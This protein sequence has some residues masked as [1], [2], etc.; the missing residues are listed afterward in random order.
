MIIVLF[1]KNLFGLD[2]RIL[3]GLLIFSN[4][5]KVYQVLANIII[6][7]YLIIVTYF[8]DDQYI[9]EN[10]TT[11][12]WMIFLLL[13]APFISLKDIIL[14]MQR[15]G[16]QIFLI[17]ILSVLYEISQGAILFLRSSERPVGIAGTLNY[18]SYFFAFLSV[19]LWDTKRRLW[20]CLSLISAFSFLSYGVILGVGLYIL[21]RCIKPMQILKIIFEYIVIILLFLSPL[22]PILFEGVGLRHVLAN[23]FIRR[24]I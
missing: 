19:I 8:N 5:A 12:I 23:N 22:I 17:S 21:Y 11:V 2:V 13:I 4:S 24:F 16:I 3:S 1:F 7:I 10:S 15:Y 14:C 20:A 9:L 18:S 6:I